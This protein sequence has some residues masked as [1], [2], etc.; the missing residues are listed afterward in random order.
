MQLLHTRERWSITHQAK[1]FPMA[2]DDY[3]TTEV[4]YYAIV[5]L[6][7]EPPF[8]QMHVSPRKTRPKPDGTPRLIVDLSW[9]V[10][11]GVNSYIPDTVFDGMEVNLRNPTVDDDIVARINELGPDS[12]LYKVDL[13]KGYRNLR[14]DPCVDV[15]IQLRLESGASG[16]QRQQIA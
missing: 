9:P 1:V 14:S 13:K 3:L 12:L 16:C 4:N 6:F 8:S 10:G 5:G 15:S 11:H 2:V 7:Q